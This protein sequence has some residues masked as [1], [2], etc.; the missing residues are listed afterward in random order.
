MNSSCIFCQI[1]NKTAPSTIVYEDEHCLGIVP[2]GKVGKGHT[3]II[4]KKHAANL[5]DIEDEEFNYVLIAAKKV[6]AQLREQ[7][8]ATGINLLHASGADAQQ[9]VFHFHFHLIP[10]YPNDGLDLWMKNKL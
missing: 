8:S 10:R 3:L 7:Y 5:F 4:P 1:V 2:L 6:A 9:T